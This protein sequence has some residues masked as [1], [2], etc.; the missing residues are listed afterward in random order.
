MDSIECFRRYVFSTYLWEIITDDK[1]TYINSFYVE[2]VSDQY[3]RV[4]GLEVPLKID[5]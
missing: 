5:G 2:I 1:V 3:T 4:L